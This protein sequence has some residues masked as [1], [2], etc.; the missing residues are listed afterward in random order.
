MTLYDI[1]ELKKIRFQQF[2]SRSFDGVLVVPSLTYILL[3][4]KYIYNV[5]IQYD[6]YKS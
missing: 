4:Y 3:H 6:I 5:I 1:Y 2:E